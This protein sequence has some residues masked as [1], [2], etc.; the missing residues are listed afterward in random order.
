MAATE[1]G[2]LYFNWDVSV[3]NIP[4]CDDI[5]GFQVHVS[6]SQGNYVQILG[7]EGSLLFDTKETYYHFVCM[8]CSLQSTVP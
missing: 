6:L 1:T 7:L 4:L 8:P 5:I 3:L 2:L